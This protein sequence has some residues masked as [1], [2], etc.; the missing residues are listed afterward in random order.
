MT[1]WD[2]V[3]YIGCGVSFIVGIFNLIN[4]NKTLP[5]EEQCEGGVVF[6]ALIC[7]VLSWAV[8]IC[9]LGYEFYK[10]LGEKK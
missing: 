8:P 5:K 4:I 3:Y 1:V 2:L 9:L 10:R 6:G 7:A